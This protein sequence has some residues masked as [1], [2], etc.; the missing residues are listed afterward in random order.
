MSYRIEY[1][2]LARQDVA[3]IREYLTQFYPSTPIKFLA[4][5]KRGIEDLSGNPF[6]YS[7][8]EDNPRYRRMVVND[9][10]VFYKVLEADRVVEIHRVL[11]GMR[12]IK[13]HLPDGG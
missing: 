10:L 13:D 3:G 7:I 5:L 6:M 11:Y 9:Y 1:L 12:N 2:E 8:Y 4:A